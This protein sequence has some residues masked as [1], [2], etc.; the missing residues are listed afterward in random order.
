ML[1]PER[2]SLTQSDRAS[3]LWFRLDEYLKAEREKLRAR[4]D[5]NLDPQETATV[6]GQ[7]QQINKILALGKTPIVTE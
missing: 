3:D 7:I 2:F 4:N 5:T 6:R 1:I